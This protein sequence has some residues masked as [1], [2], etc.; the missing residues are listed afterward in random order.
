MV[1]VDLKL[2]LLY[3]NINHVITILIELIFSSLKSH[4]PNQ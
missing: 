1:L 3:Q 4:F 2:Y